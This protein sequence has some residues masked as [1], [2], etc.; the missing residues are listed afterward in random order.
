VRKMISSGELPHFRLGGKL[1]RIRA[2]DV[3]KFEN[4]A[5]QEPAPNPL[6]VDDGISAPRKKPAARLDLPYSRLRP[7]REQGVTK[8][9]FSQGFAWC[10]PASA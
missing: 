1:L 5:E 3:E 6:P 8:R 4:E 9:D 2:T 7:A 10:W